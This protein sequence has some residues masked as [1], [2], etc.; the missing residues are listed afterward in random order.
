M[1]H[2]DAALLDFAEPVGTFQDLA[3]FGAV[4]GANDAV[5]FHEIDQVGGAP[6]ADAQAPLQQRCGRLAELEHEA[7]GVLEELVVLR[8]AAVGAGFPA[9]VTRRSLRGR[10]TFSTPS[11]QSPVRPS[12]CNTSAYSFGIC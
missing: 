5:L 11:A 2:A 4:G 7:H 8:A 1:L 3:W 9:I 6:V 12:A 10:F